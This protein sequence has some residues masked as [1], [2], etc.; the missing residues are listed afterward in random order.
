MFECHCHIASCSSQGP[1]QMLPGSPQPGYESNCPLL[2]TRS[3]VP[4]CWAAPTFWSYG[5]ISIWEDTILSKAESQNCLSL[6]TEPWAPNIYSNSTIRGWDRQVWTSQ[7]DKGDAL[8]LQNWAN[9]PTFNDCATM[10]MIRTQCSTL[11]IPVGKSRHTFTCDLD[12]CPFWEW[13]PV[14]S[15]PN[16]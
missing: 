9:V 3:A 10:P 4:P 13:F 6:D 7:W 14:F 16:L 12:R 8:M 2:W 11:G 1:G 15:S 5:K